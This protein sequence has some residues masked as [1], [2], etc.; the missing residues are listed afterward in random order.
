MSDT[1]ASLE[2]Q[3]GQG[4]KVYQKLQQDFTNAVEARQRLD[5][6]KAEN[7]AVKKEFATLLPTNQVFKLVGPVLFK[8]DQSEAK[9]NVDNRLELINNEIKRVETQ[10]SDVE[11][12]LESKKM[13]LVHIQTLLQQKAQADAGGAP[14]A[15]K[16]IQGVLSA[17]V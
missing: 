11:G 16:Q 13:E 7:E 8:Q 12:K 5:A 1:I 4:T 9:G 14:G 15:A 3:L 10:I 17:A 2:A 6:Q